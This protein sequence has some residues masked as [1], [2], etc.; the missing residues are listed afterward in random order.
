MEEFANNN[1]VD[2][3]QNDENDNILERVSVN[4]MSDY[5]N[6]IHTRPKQIN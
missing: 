6:A 2:K 1:F 3:T 5:E 4:I